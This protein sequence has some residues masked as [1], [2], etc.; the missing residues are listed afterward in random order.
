M[1]LLPIVFLSGCGGGTG[2]VKGKITVNGKPLPNGQITFLSQVGNRD[3]FS[4]A[5]VDG[6]YTT[7]EIPV[8]KAR[9]III[10]AV[11]T[12]DPGGTVKGGG[13]VDPVAR[14]SK[15]AGYFDVP[16]RYQ[17]AETSGL[18][19]MIKKGPNEF[20]RDLRE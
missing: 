7:S 5:I 20:S 2:T 1:F 11:D 6:E 15:K 9:I 4:A 14:S 12:G 19:I 10:P 17:N 3:P 16:E 8:G 13:D 18:E